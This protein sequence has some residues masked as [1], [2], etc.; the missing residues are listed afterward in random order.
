MFVVAY[1][2]KMTIYL[3]NQKNIAYISEH[4][5]R[6]IYMQIQTRTNFSDL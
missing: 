3:N 6:P 5:R 1:L 2:I 4:K